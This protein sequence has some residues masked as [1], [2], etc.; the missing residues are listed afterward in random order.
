MSRNTTDV[1][2][3][4]HT[5]EVYTNYCCLM[6]CLTPL[7]PECIDDHNKNHKN[8]GE[9]PEIDTIKKV[10]T[11]CHKKLNFINSNLK[12]QLQR[13]NN[14]EH[15]SIENK[16]NKFISDLNRIRE[17]ILGQV[18]NYFDDLEAHYKN[19]FLQNK[20]RDF[21]KL[22][23]EISNIISDINLLDNNLDTLN[24]L[25]SIKKSIKLNKESILKDTISKVDEALSH[26]INIPVKIELSEV[27]LK[28][29][30]DRLT[31]LV[32]AE[33]EVINIKNEYKTDINNIQIYD[34]VHNYFVGKFKK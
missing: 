31:D 13:L 18:N 22:K 25:D 24:K 5:D 28:A 1:I 11:M 27:N 12:E 19:I 20:A 26:E 3:K 8:T 4:N 34:K 23:K 15:I 2:C 17:L 9:F 32:R 29:F 10:C 30:R 16:M 33:K 21:Y 6:T 7:C 14:A